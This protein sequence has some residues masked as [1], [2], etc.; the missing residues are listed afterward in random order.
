M[1]FCIFVW[2]N[3]LFNFDVRVWGVLWSWRWIT[4]FELHGSFQDM[5]QQ[6]EHIM[7]KSSNSGCTRWERMMCFDTRCSFSSFLDKK[8]VLQKEFYDVKVLISSNIP[9]MHL[10]L[11]W[12]IWI[13]AYR[14]LANFALPSLFLMMKVSCVGSKGFLIRKHSNKRLLTW[15]RQE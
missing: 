14:K 10:W 1:W 15:V 6:K 4:G 13:M 9:I 8:K 12:Y 5:M 11:Q 3:F 2:Q 7:I